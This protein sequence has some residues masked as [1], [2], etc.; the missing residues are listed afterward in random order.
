MTANQIG[1]VPR[2]N[3]ARQD[4]PHRHLRGFGGVSIA[5]G[6]GHGRI[7]HQEQW[8][9]EKGL[10]RGVSGMTGDGGRVF[11]GLRASFL[12]M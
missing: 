6:G 2:R 8:I 3:D 5:T 10:T 7:T 1:G 4:H 11:W 12:K 9:E